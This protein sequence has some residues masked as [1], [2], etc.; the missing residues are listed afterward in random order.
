[1]RYNSFSQSAVLS[2]WLSLD[3]IFSFVLPHMTQTPTLPQVIHAASLFDL[4]LVEKAPGP[5]HCISSISS[6]LVNTPVRLSFFL[7]HC[8][9]R[10]LGSSTLSQGREGFAA[11]NRRKVSLTSHSA[12]VR[13]C[14]LEICWRT[15]RSVARFPLPLVALVDLSTPSFGTGQAESNFEM[16]YDFIPDPLITSLFLRVFAVWR[17][18]RN[19][20]IER[21]SL[22]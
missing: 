22:K 1:M 14:K 9:F 6:T 2:R 11:G 18:P 3:F 12:R 5:G 19:K 4:F 7:L 16:K 21:S 20:R 17:H 13:F 15:Y 8:S 10:S